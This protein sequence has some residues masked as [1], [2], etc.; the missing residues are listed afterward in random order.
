ML[1]NCV[2]IIGGKWRGRKIFFPNI[3]GLRPSPDRVRETL[4][5]WLSPYLQD[6]VCLDLY[7]GSGV[8]GFEALSR[9]AQKVI[10]VDTSY[11]VIRQL[12]EDKNILHCDTLEI[13][14]QSAMDFFCHAK[15]QFD[16][17]FLD[18]PFAQNLIEPTCQALAQSNL[19]KSKA[20]IYIE[21]ESNKNILTLPANWEIV[22]QKKAGQVKYFLVKA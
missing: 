15:E 18:P 16:I 12:H 8:L 11:E 13:Y 5:N 22:K 14:H 20:F 21:M 9:G 17:I 7:A 3:Q 19:L 10:F 6:S 1:R 4:F 2:R